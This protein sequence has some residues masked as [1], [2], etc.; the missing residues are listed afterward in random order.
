[1][2]EGLFEVG[3][4][5]ATLAQSLGDRRMAAQI[6]HFGGRRRR[7]P[8]VAEEDPGDPVSQTC[9]GAKPQSAA[10]GMADGERD[11]VGSDPIEDRF[12]RRLEIRAEGLPR[13]GI[14]SA[15]FRN[16]RR[17]ALSAGVE[18]DHAVA[19]P[20]RCRGGSQRRAA[21]SVRVMHQD[22][23]ALAPE[24]EG[25]KFDI[26]RC[27]RHPEAFGPFEQCPRSV[28]RLCPHFISRPCGLHL[29]CHLFR[30]AP[31]SQL[32]AVSPLC[33]RGPSG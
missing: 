4:M 20:Q 25:R 17:I 8:G 14:G 27:A 29:L 9:R 15:P 30:L 5:V 18:R 22:Q 16:R 7:D 31:F 24:I 6:R 12:C 32:P 21:E 19:I 11:A 13:V 23:R 3:P 28:P 26:G 10:D 1:M 2:H 33:K